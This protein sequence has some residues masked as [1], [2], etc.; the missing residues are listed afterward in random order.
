MFFNKSD[1]KIINSLDNII[2]Y[3]NNKTNIIDQNDF[4]ERAKCA[5]FFG[6]LQAG[7]T[8]FHYLRPIWKETTEKD[9]EKQI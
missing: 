6:T 4:N 3:L 1:K 9:T 7:F 5:S 8:D 2:D